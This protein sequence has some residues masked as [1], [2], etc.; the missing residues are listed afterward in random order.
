MAVK[1]TEV[2]EAN[3]LAEAA[4]ETLTGKF[5]FPVTVLVA[6]TGLP[7]PLLTV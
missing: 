6:V 2:P 5:W 1:V 7:Q 3:G 4:M